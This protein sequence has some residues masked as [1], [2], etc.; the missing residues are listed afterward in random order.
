VSSKP[1]FLIHGKFRKVGVKKTKDI[2]F[3]EPLFL[4]YWEVSSCVDFGWSRFQGRCNKLSG[5]FILLTLPCRLPRAPMGN[6]TGIVQ[7]ALA[8]FSC[9]YFQK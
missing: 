2:P 5:Q 4:K 3:P 9:G 7:A 6:F 1:G 8:L